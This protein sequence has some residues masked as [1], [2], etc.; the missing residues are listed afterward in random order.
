[1]AQHYLLCAQQCTILRFFI[2]ETGS[3]SRLAKVSFFRR[4]LKLAAS[5][6]L[7]PLT[8]N[9]DVTSATSAEHREQ[10]LSKF[11]QYC[12]AKESAVGFQVAKKQVWNGT[13]SKRG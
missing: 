12:D 9:L 4:F 2:Q 6:K 11:R 10:V 8:S 7:R 5:G 3:A 13:K 1:M